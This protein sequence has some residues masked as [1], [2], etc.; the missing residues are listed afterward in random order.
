MSSTLVAQL[1]LFS[2][3]DFPFL[4]CC[5]AGGENFEKSFFF[6]LLDVLQVAKQLHLVGFEHQEY[7]RT[8]SFEKS[9]PT[10]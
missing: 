7:V 4:E 5:P 6:N 2:F 10:H 9:Y 1:V 8:L 3:D